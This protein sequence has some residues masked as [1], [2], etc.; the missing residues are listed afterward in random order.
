MTAIDGVLELMRSQS[1][2]DLSPASSRA[3]AAARGASKKAGTKPELLLR[4]ALW[5]A[6]YRYRKNVQGIPGHPDLVFPG[7]RVVVFCDGD[8]WHGKNWE[9]RRKKLKNGH[10]AEY[11]VAKIQCNMERDKQ[12]T[13]DLEQDGWHVIR[14]WESDLKRNID[15]AVRRVAQALEKGDR[16]G[17]LLK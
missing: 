12:H 13:Q 9:K 5:R 10:N 4:R 15:D 17:K 11:W 2:K 7:P 8:F 14:I 1:Y 3:S 6:G 16:R